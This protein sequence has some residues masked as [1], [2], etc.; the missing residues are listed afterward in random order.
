MNNFGTWGLEE[1]GSPLTSDISIVQGK[2]GGIYVGRG[3][4]CMR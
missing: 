2:K 3:V 1:L 4:V